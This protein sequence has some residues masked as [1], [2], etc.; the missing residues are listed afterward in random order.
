MRLAT[1]AAAVALAATTAGPAGAVSNAAEYLIAK[2]ISDAC[3][4]GRG[5]FEKAL[6]RDVTG[7]GKADLLLDHQDLQCEGGQ[8]FTCGPALPPGCLVTFYVREGALLIEKH[9]YMGD[10]FS[11]GRGDP[12]TIRIVDVGGPS[13]KLGG[14]VRERSI[15]WNGRAF[16]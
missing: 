16:K 6:E 2:A 9:S 5:R 7:D 15:R 3:E 8:T 12:P 4:S 13:K 11:I 10:G 1:T 14:A